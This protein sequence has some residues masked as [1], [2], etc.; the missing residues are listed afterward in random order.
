MRLPQQK[1]RRSPV[2]S[3]TN[4]SFW[5]ILGVLITLALPLTESAH[6]ITPQGDLHR[7]AQLPNS[8]GFKVTATGNTRFRYPPH[9]IDATAQQAHYDSATKQ[10]VLKGNVRLRQRGKTIQGDVVTCRLDT[11][12]C[13]PV[14]ADPNLSP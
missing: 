9:D 5:Q 14:K 13:T 1:N 10:M 2:S 4:Q 8:P 7:I 12:Q 3:R 11:G 6:A